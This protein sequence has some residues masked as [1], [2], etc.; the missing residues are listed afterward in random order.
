MTDLHTR[1][2]SVR[3]S[4]KEIAAI[5]FAGTP[6]WK[7]A[8]L[9]RSTLVEEGV[10]IDVASQLSLLV[11]VDFA[12]VTEDDDYVGDIALLM[13]EVLGKEY[14]MLIANNFKYHPHAFDSFFRDR[15]TISLR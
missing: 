1:K 7:F 8:L 12:D 10:P 11:K 5:D 14:K 6:D 13:A 4:L 2:E 9:L 3:A 15:Y